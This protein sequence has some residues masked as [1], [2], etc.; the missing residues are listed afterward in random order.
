MII[1]TALTGHFFLD[2]LG[3][4]RHLAR[5]SETI[6]KEPGFSQ[7]GFFWRKSEGHPVGPGQI[8]YCHLP[9]GD[10]KCR[11]ARCPLLGGKRTSP[12]CAFTSANDP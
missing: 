6:G 9:A 8:E 3:A 7:P 2:F 12:F 4:R 1:P 5:C 11:P 10:S